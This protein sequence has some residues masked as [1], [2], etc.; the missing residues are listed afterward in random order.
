MTLVVLAGTLSI[1][2]QA[3]ALHPEHAMDVTSILREYPRM[4]AWRHVSPEASS[5]TAADLPRHRI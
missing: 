4:P 3:V 1:P 5:Q 2:N